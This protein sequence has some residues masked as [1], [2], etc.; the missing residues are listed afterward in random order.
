MRDVSNSVQLVGQI[1]DTL[2][3]DFKT[4]TRE[5][6]N[7]FIADDCLTL[8]FQDLRDK[9]ILRFDAGKSDYFNLPENEN[10]FYSEI[11][12]TYF[13]LVPNDSSNLEQKV[14]I[15]VEDLNKIEKDK[16]NYIKQLEDL[17]GKEF[18]EGKNYKEKLLIHFINKQKEAEEQILS[19]IKKHLSTETNK[20]KYQLFT[21][22]QIFPD[23]TYHYNFAPHTYKLEFLSEIR[24]KLGN[25]I[26]GRYFELE[27]LYQSDKTK[28]LEE[29][30]KDF[31]LGKTI[32]S[33]KISVAKNKRLS[34]RK[35]LIDVILDLLK[36]GKT[37]LFCN[38]VPQQIEGILYDYCIEFGIDKKSLVNSTLGDKIN[39]LVEKGNT[40]ID[41]EYF[42]FIFPLIRNRVAHG[43]LIEQNLDL[44][45]WLL[46]LDLK[47]AC[48]WLLSNKLDSNKNLHFV[49]Y[50]NNQSD[51]IELIKIAPI[52]KSGIDEFY[53]D[54][55][56]KLEEH[57]ESLRTKLLDANFPYG[58]VS[59]D[60]KETVLENLRELKKIGIND[61]E[62]KKIMDKI[63]CAF[64]SM[65]AEVV[66]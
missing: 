49:N 44:N 5:F 2:N 28:F 56:I 1:H 6:L 45:S 19:Y 35:D 63:N 30:K 65:A 20:N 4:L 43:K 60:N 29:L 7:Y 18:E 8:P 21:S 22:F 31:S 23:Y 40:E 52:I 14:K 66:N 53:N 51:I 61:Q 11:C 50:L 32:N 58:S 10:E 24:N 48:E 46:L 47:S 26:L 55:K 3:S 38:V 12:K 16:S 37:Q 57:K 34:Q 17:K 36:K 9:Y 27:K 15:I 41:Y 33:I 62:C 13:C 54:A 39:L 59:A 25:V 64:G 42:A